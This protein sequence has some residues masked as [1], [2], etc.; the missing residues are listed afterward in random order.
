[1]RRGGLTVVRGLAVLLALAAVLSTTAGCRSAKIRRGEIPHFGS[2]FAKF[3][4]VRLRDLV[5]GDRRV[6]RPL[7]A[8]YDHYG[9]SHRDVVLAIIPNTVSGWRPGSLATDRLFDTPGVR[10]IDHGAHRGFEQL[11]RS[12]VFVAATEEGA[13]NTVLS[14]LLDDDAGDRSRTGVPA[15]VVVDGLP[16]EKWPVV[17]VTSEILVRFRRSFLDDADRGASPRD[18]VNR[19]LR[20]RWDASVLDVHD[21]DPRLHLIRVNARR[22]QGW[23]RIARDIRG[24]P[25]CDGLAEPN[26]LVAHVTSSDEPSQGVEP[27]QLPQVAQPDT[28]Q[29]PTDDPLVEKQ[30]HLGASGARSAWRRPVPT[31]RGSRDVVV[32]VIEPNGV[33]FTHPDLAGNQ[34]A[35]WHRN[36]DDGSKDPEMRREAPDGTQLT[37]AHG[38]ATTGLVAAVAGNG[39][40]V[41]GVAPDCRFMAI[42]LGPSLYD[43]VRAFDYAWRVGASV[44]SN[45]WSYPIGVDVPDAVRCAVYR[46]T[47]LGRGGNGCVVLFS[48]TNKTYDNF[49]DDTGWADAESLCAEMEQPRF[50]QTAPIEPQS[51]PATLP[52]TPIWR[53]LAAMPEVMAIGRCTDTEKWGRCG[54]G[55]GMS[56][57]APS[58]AQAATKARG[59]DWTNFIGI[60]DVTTTD[61]TGDDGQNGQAGFNWGSPAGEPTG[62]CACSNSSQGTRELNDGNYTSCFKGTSAAVPIVAA[63]AALVI[64]EYPDA[65][66]AD[67]R[68][69]LEST[70]V[71]M[72]E[73]E[74]QYTWDAER[75]HAYSPRLG[76]GRVHAGEACAAAARL[77]ES[78]ALSAEVG[79]SGAGVLELGEMVDAGSV[80]VVRAAPSSGASRVAP[81]ARTA[82]APNARGGRASGLV[83]VQ[84]GS[85]R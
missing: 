9:Q 69:L 68:R 46:A 28:D 3:D 52:D 2:W 49:A 20:D 45:S 25:E 61:L 34:V 66:G 72:D 79:A 13:R 60:A 10:G 84:S 14:S 19:L 56:L 30:W 41:S 55:R 50:A 42:C 71:T 16:K 65:T 27:T 26:L 36:F 47:T 21:A 48:L 81:T 80:V 44:L 24:A 76:Y 54:Y 7:P 35:A 15:F 59:C 6:S 5:G 17:V 70:A 11:N 22:P 83:T 12:G 40:G 53:P 31:A 38:T 18:R 63:A 43:D 4:S 29:L 82:T 39:I 85:V 67:I 33:Q 1:L 8:G 73:E 62:K 51:A 78:R 77:R 37:A 64:S 58:N 57:V 32:A 23:L 74:G 75:G